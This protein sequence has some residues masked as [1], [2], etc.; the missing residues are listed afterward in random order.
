MVGLEMLSSEGR[1]VPL[2]EVAKTAGISRRYLELL[3]VSLRNAGLIRGHPG[4]DG[5][6]TLSRTASEIRVGEIVEAAIGTVC[7]IDCLETADTC[8]QSTSCLCRPL[9]RLVN[10]RISETLFE[11]TLADMV[12]EDW[13]DRIDGKMP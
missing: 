7:I 8:E 3:S 2:V 1:P 6:F 4:R 5:G 13:V 12:R 11:F 9:W 10:H